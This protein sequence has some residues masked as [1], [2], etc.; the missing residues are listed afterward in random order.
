MTKITCPNDMLNRIWRIFASQGISDDLQIIESLAYLLLAKHVGKWEEV[1]REAQ[2][3]RLSPFLKFDDTFNDLSILPISI[4]LKVDWPKLMAFNSFERMKELIDLVGS[5]FDQIDSATLLNHCLMMRLDNMQA[6]GRYPTPRHLSNFIANLVLLFNSNRKLDVI[7][8][9]CGSGGLLAEFDQIHTMNG[10]EVS[11]IWARIARANLFLHG[12]N[13]IYTG[14]TLEVA[15]RLTRNFDAVVMNPPFGHPL[16]KELVRQ[17]LGE[18]VGQRSETVLTLLAL[19]CLKQ[20]GVLAVL[21]PAGTLFSSSS[22]EI[23][24]RTRLLTENRL[25]AIIQLPKDAFQP[26]SQLQ[27]YLLVARNTPQSTVEADVPVWFYHIAHDGFSSGRNRQPQPE[28]NQL[29]QLLATVAAGQSE[30]ALTAYDQV[31]QLQLTVQPLSTGGYRVIQPNGGKLTFHTLN[32]PE[33]HVFWLTRQGEETYHALL[34]EGALWLERSEPTF[35]TNNTLRP[36]SLRL[37]DDSNQQVELKK[38]KTTWKLFL[39][40]TLEIVPS[41]TLAPESGYLGLFFDATLKLLSPLLEVPTTLA[42]DY[43]PKPLTRLFLEDQDNRPAGFFLLW[44]ASMLQTHFFASV[45]GENGW[46]MLAGKE[47]AALL[48]WANETHVGG[49]VWG[50]LKRTFSGKS[51]HRGVVVNAQGNCFGVGVA[52]THI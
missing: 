20:N 10:I 5:L 39:K 29:P 7:D 21:Q 23:L 2:L 31:G 46:L 22:G 48:G 30:N 43:T 25:E 4:L 6:G 16:E 50:Q 40:T 37:V 18:N 42:K 38:E 41:Q 49:V 11:P 35:L 15:A 44:N 26:Y 45:T 28:Q 24:L 8:F 27:N 47:E 19:N 36:I 51:W 12:Q 17:A 3:R 1:K 52:P 33:T 34:Y 14:N 32:L 9:A 13:L